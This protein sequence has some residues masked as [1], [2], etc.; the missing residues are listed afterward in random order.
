MKNRIGVSGDRDLLQHENSTHL[1]TLIFNNK[2]GTPSDGVDTGTELH[3]NRMSG[4]YSALY[5]DINQISE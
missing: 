5:L 2:I 3:S 1:E 4:K